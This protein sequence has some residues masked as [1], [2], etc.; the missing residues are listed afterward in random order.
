MNK[1]FVGGLVGLLLS[2]PLHYYVFEVPPVEIV[3]NI[4]PLILGYLLGAFVMYK[5]E[6]NVFVTKHRYLVTIN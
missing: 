4:T 5:N 2:I 1:V 6:E 3:R